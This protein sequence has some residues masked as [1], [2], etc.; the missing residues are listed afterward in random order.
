MRPAHLHFMVAAP[1]YRTL[2]T[3]VFVAGDEY[4]ASDAVFGAK[5][6]LVVDVADHPPGT[7]PDG[8]E[9]AQAWASIEFDIV[10][11]EEPAEK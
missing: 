7:A 3:H 8:G 5:D 4:L 2:I 1:G 11:A 9:L 10:L 6:S